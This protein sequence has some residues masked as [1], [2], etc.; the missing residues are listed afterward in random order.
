MTTATV[1][2]AKSQLARA[3]QTFARPARYLEGVPSVKEGDSSMPSVI[4]DLAQL[5]QAA[6]QLIEILHS[7]TAEDNGNDR[8]ELLNVASALR[9]AAFL[10]LQREVPEQAWFWTPEWQ[11]GERAADADKRAG[12]TTI[13]PS[14]NE[15]LAALRARRPHLADT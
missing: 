2:N 7:A 4:N 5:I 13:Q 12:L 3:A 6:D 8:E 10:L 15:F 1:S 11:A 14:D 9:R